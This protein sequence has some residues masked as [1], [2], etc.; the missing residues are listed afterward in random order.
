MVGW[1]LQLNGHEFEQT[2]GDSEGQGSLVCCSPWSHEESDTTEPLNDSYNQVF[3]KINVTSS[4]QVLLENS[5]EETP[6]TSERDLKIHIPKEQPKKKTQN[7][8]TTKNLDLEQ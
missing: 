7:K 5:R 1:H 3:L 8:A 6:P 2:L 4:I